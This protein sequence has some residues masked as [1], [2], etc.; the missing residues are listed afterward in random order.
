[1]EASGLYKARDAAHSAWHTHRR[2]GAIDIGIREFSRTTRVPGQGIGLPGWDA[3]RRRRIR[4][5]GLLHSP[6]DA[7]GR[8]TTLTP[9]FPSGSIVSP[10]DLAFGRDLEA[11]FVAYHMTVIANTPPHDRVDPCI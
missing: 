5:P 1:M 6:A 2:R 3:T 11:E 7:G 8:K 9:T 10:Y 4:Y